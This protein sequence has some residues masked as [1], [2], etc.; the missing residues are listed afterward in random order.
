MRQSLEHPHRPAELA[1]PRDRRARFLRLSLLLPPFAI[2]FFSIFEPWARA[3]VTLVWGVSRSPEAAFLLTGAVA[4]VFVASAVAIWTGRRIG[5]AGAVHMAA[6]LL[7]GA[8]A[9][10]AFE[11]VRDAGVKA[12][13]LLPLVSVRPGRGLQGFALAATF[14]ALL[15]LT[16]L[17][18]AAWRRRRARGRRARATPPADP[19]AA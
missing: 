18:F 7:L 13:W 3:R 1:L 8:I 4:L 15:G 11:M 14:L 5:L 19:G 12:F 9:W 16:E 6:G 17:L 10:Q 2:A